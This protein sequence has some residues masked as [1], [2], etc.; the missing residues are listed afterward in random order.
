MGPTARSR[1]EWVQLQE[2]VDLIKITQGPREPSPVRGFL[3][4]DGPPAAETPHPAYWVKGGDGTARTRSKTARIR[5]NGRP[6]HGL[7]SCEGHTWPAEELYGVIEAAFKFQV[8]HLAV[9]ERKTVA[10]DSKAVRVAVLD[11]RMKQLETDFKAGHLSAVDYAQHLTGVATEREALTRAPN[12]K[13]VTR[14]VDV[15]DHASDCRAAACKCPVLTYAKWWDSASPVERREKLVTWGVRGFVG[16]R[17]LRFE[18]GKDFPAP[19]RL[20]EL[21]FDGSHSRPGPGTVSVV[22]DPATNTAELMLDGEQVTALPLP[23]GARA[24]TLAA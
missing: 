2:V 1:V 7:K 20:A 9:Q 3:F 24:L 17:G 8:G 5:C 12:T 22:V 23:S 21:R 15:K 16:K 4:C 10:D 11:A 6:S 13:P 18:Y 19:V 14:W